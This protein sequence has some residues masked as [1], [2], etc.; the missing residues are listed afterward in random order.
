MSF[1]WRTF[2]AVCTFA[3]L[4]TTGM[5]AGPSDVLSPVSAGTLEDGKYVNSLIGF[6]YAYPKDWLVKSL[7]NPHITGETATYPLLFLVHPQDSKE[8]SVLEVLAQDLR[9]NSRITLE[10]YAAEKHAGSKE[11]PPTLKPI[12]LGGKPFVRTES[13]E[14]VGGGTLRYMH[15]FSIVNGYGLDFLM[16]TNNKERTE[17]FEK[18]LTSLSFFDGHVASSSLEGSASSSPIQTNLLVSSGEISGGIYRNKY[19]RVSYSIPDDFVPMPE[20]MT[21][22][23][24]NQVIRLFSLSPRTTPSVESKLE[25]IELVAERLPNTAITPNTYRDITVGGTVNKQPYYFTQIK[26]V[27]A[28]ELPAGRFAHAE[29]QAN[30]QVAG[31][32]VPLFLADL[33]TIRNNYALTFRASAASHSRVTELLKT[34]ESMRIEGK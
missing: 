34:A 13:Q 4:Q 22:A 11:K 7:P 25:K 8:I 14:K 23:S 28:I 5:A 20:E 10:E 21:S 1:P 26:S 33:I 15:A 9:A 29:F 19:F 16:A 27:D 17:L 2:T 31:K 12:L 3:L 6:S 24:S 30:V 18:T 32:S